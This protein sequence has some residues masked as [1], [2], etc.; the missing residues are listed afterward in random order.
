MLPLCKSVHPES[1]GDLGVSVRL[2][3]GIKTPG[4]WLHPHLCVTYC[5]TFPPFLFLPFF[6]FVSCFVFSHCPHPGV[7]WLS[8]HG[9]SHPVW[10]YR[11]NPSSY[12]KT[13]L[14]Q[15]FHQFPVLPRLPPSFQFP[16][17]MLSPAVSPVLPSLKPTSVRGR[18]VDICATLTPTVVRQ[19]LQAPV[20]HVLYFS[21]LQGWAYPSM[22]WVRGVA[23][24]R[25]HWMQRLEW[26][27]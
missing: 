12:F 16:H 6:L 3:D 9:I 10:S 26:L 22:H 23:L 20:F 17:A 25:G 24:R 8:Q 5:V 13:V 1:Q 27:K 14:H 18:H 2:T 15:N 19:I 7:L 21:N 11:A 4:S